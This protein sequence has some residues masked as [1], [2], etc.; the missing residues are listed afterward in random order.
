MEPRRIRA[1]AITAAGV[2]AALAATSVARVIEVVFGA[3]RPD[4]LEYLGAM[5]RVFGSDWFLAPVP[6]ALAVLAGFAWWLPIRAELRMRQVVRRGLATAAVGGALVV[7]AGILVAGGRLAGSARDGFGGAELERFG[8]AVLSAVLR[9][10][11]L[12]AVALLAVPLA[13][14]LLWGYLRRAVPGSWGGPS[15]ASV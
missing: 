9:P 15:G 4:P 12:V 1:T 7:L 8:E 5:L 2:Y 3:Y 10:V 13:G 11:D 14:L 6:I